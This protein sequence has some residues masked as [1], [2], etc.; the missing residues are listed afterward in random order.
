MNG[1]YFYHFAKTRKN[2]NYGLD[3]FAY[4]ASQRWKEELEKKGKKLD[5]EDD[6]SDRGGDGDDADRN[7]VDVL[8]W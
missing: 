4:F 1:E 8:P 2:V 6:A 5:E 7:N 3:V